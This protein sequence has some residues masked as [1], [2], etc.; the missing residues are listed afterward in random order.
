MFLTSL[1]D[2]E[3]D[4]IHPTRTDLWRM[5]GLVT[6]YHDLPPDAVD[7]SVLAVAERTGDHDIATLDRHHFSVARP[8]CSHNLTI[9]PQ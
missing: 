4:P 7:A 2:S 6:A 1:A 8:A 5:A 9:H 3:F